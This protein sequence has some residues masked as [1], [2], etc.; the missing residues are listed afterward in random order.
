MVLF[1]L[2][3][4]AGFAAGF[5]AHQLMPIALHFLFMIVAVGVKFLLVPR[6]QALRF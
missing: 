3:L 4:L 2:C 6:Y 1:M 5:Y